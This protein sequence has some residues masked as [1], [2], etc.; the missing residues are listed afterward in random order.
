MD[1]KD[2]LIT[3]I[4]FSSI[5]IGSLMFIGGVSGNYDTE[6]ASFVNDSA[7]RSMGAVENTSD[8][9]QSKINATQ[10][11]Q[12]D[13]ISTVFGSVFNGV[14]VLVNTGPTMYMSM[15]NAA[16]STKVVPGWAVHMASAIVSV[17]VLYLVIKL[18]LGS[19]VSGS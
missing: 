16:E 7:H 17:V 1:L 11:S 2:F 8:E 14:K 9:L 6:Q 18:L 13:P 4:V 15:V 12:G 5:A 19:R 3:A 10:V